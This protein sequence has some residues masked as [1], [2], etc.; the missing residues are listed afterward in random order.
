MAVFPAESFGKTI[1]PSLTLIRI[2][3]LV[4]GSAMFIQQ[5]IIWQTAV[6]LPLT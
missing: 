6:T 2:M 4:A 3:T 5:P 1:S